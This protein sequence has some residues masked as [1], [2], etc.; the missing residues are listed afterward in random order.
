MS[1]DLALLRPAPGQSWD[2]AYEALE[3]DAGL[4]FDPDLWERVAAAARRVLPALDES[5]DEDGRELTHEPTGL[6]LSLYGRELSLTV[7]YWYEG[8]QARDLVALLRR[9]VGAVEGATGLTAYD[10]Q[11]EAPFL[12]GGADGAVGVFDG[13]A[14]SFRDSGVLT[15]NGEVPRRR[16][17]QRLVGR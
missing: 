6:Q 10:P 1:Y 3:D 5:G 11:V 17:W 13:V 16:W 8:G 4:P 14:G 7:P 15:G 2:E 9:L 12:D